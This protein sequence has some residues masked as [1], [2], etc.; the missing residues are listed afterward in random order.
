MDEASGWGWAV[1]QKDGALAGKLFF[2]R[3]NE[4][5]FR[6]VKKAGPVKAAATTGMRVIR[7]T[8]PTRKP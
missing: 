2:H 7:L 1:L 6:A 3:G 5:G 8:W 4:S